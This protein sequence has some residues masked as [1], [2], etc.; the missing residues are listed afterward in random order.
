MGLS[1]EY[2][3]PDADGFG[4]FDLTTANAEIA[5]DLENLVIIPRD[6]GRCRE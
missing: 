4:V 6:R 5:N 3:D 2:C 1:L